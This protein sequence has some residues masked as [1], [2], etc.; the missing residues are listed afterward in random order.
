MVIYVREDILSKPS[1]L[2]EISNS[3]GSIFIEFSLRCVSVCVCVCV[4]VCLFHSP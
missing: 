3:L 4:C 2:V 1:K